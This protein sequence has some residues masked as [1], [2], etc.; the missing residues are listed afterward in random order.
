MWLCVSLRSETFLLLTS[1]R[2]FLRRFLF[3]YCSCWEYKYAMSVWLLFKNSK[4]NNTAVI[5][6]YTN[7]NI[8][9]MMIKLWGKLWRF[10]L[11]YPLPFALNII[12]KDPFFVTCNHIFEEH[13]ISLLWK[14]T[15]CY[16]YAIFLV[17]LSRRVWRTQMPILLTFPFS[18]GGWL[19]IG[20]CWNQDYFWTTFV[21]T[22]FHQFS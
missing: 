22:A 17:L 5:P 12:I 14:K 11:V 4:M 1:V 15:C 20:M 7:H 9:S 2:H 3:T 13:V 19:W 6:P 10:I 21:R 16:G 18:S 8:C